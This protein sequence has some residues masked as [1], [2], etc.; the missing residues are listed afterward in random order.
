MRKL[1]LLLPL[2]ITACYG[3]LG[4]D[5]TQ[6]G[7]V[8][9]G[10]PAGQSNNY[11][12]SVSTKNHLWQV[13]HVDDAPRTVVNQ[14]D[15]CFDPQIRQGNYSSLNQVAL[16]NYQNAQMDNEN[17]EDDNISLYKHILNK[18]CNQYGSDNDLRKVDQR[19]LSCFPHDGYG[20][21]HPWLATNPSPACA[22]FAKKLKD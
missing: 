4:V 16:I 20:Y 11:A 14:I 2:L 19:L 21:Q 5:Y 9:G 12:K 3:Y 18:L 7:Q 1:F 22:E 17:D 10:V 13:G 15:K 8:Y 6:A